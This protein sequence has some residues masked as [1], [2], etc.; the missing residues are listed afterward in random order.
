MK[1]TFLGTGAS[2]GIPAFRCNCPVCIEAREKKGRHFR[3]NAAVHFESDGGVK[4]LIDMP[5]QIKMMLEKYSL[6]DAALDLILFTHYH[7]DHTAGLFH[8]LE[9]LE[10]NGHV[11]GKPVKVFMPEDCHETVMD[12][13]FPDQIDMRST[14]YS[15]FYSLEILKALQK[16]SEGMLE[17]QALNTNHLSGSRECH[18]YLFTENGKRA[19]YM[20]D[21]SSQLPPQTLEALSGIDCLIF[22]NT[23]DVFPDKGRGHSDHEGVLKIRN[24]LKPERMILSHI[25]HRNFSHDRLAAFMEKHGIET[26]WD[27]ME[28]LI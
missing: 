19:A 23:F 16:T 27:G 17:I 1:I 25:S 7:I 18:G 15:R 12:G 4:I 21:S 9:S 24:L 28:V 22:E 6:S 11:P 26:A 10:R 13:I 2:E 20:V 3:Q 8:L 14:D 5:A